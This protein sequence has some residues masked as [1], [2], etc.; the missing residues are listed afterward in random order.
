ME[1]LNEYILRYQQYK[2]G[3]YEYE[4]IT[5]PYG[6]KRIVESGKKIVFVGSKTNSIAL[7]ITSGTI[8]LIG[9]IVGILMT[10]VNV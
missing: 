5:S 10:K 8:L 6:V 1:N 7:F 2:E 9:L 3:N 4:T